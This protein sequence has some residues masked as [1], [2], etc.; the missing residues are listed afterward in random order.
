MYNSTKTNH[1]NYSFFSYLQRGLQL[2]S[3]REF[4]AFRKRY[5]PDQSCLSNLIM[6][7]DYYVAFFRYGAI[8]SD[9]FEYQFWK[10]KHCERREYVTMFFSRKI[11]HHYNHG[12]KEVFIDK[13]KFN[14]IYR[15]FRTIKSFDM[16]RGGRCFCRICE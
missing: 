3:I 2:C 1:G 13:L 12:D 11:Q 10:K 4:K 6:L 9:Y 7:I 15:D 5:L 16:Q 14:E 8:V